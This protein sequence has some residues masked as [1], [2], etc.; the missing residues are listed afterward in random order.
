M[1]GKSRMRTPTIGLFQ[2]IAGKRSMNSSFNLLA[3]VL[4]A[5]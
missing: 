5:A 2:T 1:L 4:E 3:N